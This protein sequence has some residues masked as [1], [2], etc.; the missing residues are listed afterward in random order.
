[1]VRQLREL[2][3]GHPEAKPQIRVEASKTGGGAAGGSGAARDRNGMF[4]RR[5]TN[6]DGTLSRV[7]FLA[8]QPDADS[9]SARFMK[10]DRDGDGSLSRD[11]FVG[12]DSKSAKP[13]GSAR[14]TI[15]GR[16]SE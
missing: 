10:M 6:G 1:V 12:A 14:N 11:E 4:D 13:A 9:G 5:D 16:D 2:L 7:E 15:P 8:S 3:A